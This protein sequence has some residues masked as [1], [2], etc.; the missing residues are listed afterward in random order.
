MGFFF[1]VVDFRISDL[2]QQIALSGA[3]SAPLLREEFRLSLLEEAQSYL[4]RPEKEVVGSGDNIVRQQI[5]T[6]EDFPTES[7]FR[8]LKD[9]FQ[10]LLSQSLA[11]VEPFPFDSALNFNAMVL[12]KYEKGSLGI[13]P[14]RD[15]LAHINLITVFVLGGQGT[16]CVCADRSGRDSRV[17]HAA[18]GSVI[19]LRAPGFQG[20][21]ERPFHYV[22]DIRE[23][24][25][26]FGLRQRQP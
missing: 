9:G 26:T 22:T 20:K 1:S 23:T 7:R 15:R 2:L 14:H 8:T 4:Y 3:T 16:F 24:R 17:I 25:Y 19:F 18:P 13:T 21:Q 5:R 6:F 12:Q 10:T 11:E